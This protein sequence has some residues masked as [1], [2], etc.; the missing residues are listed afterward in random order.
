MNAPPLAELARLDD[1][2][3][4]RALRRQARS[5]A[6]GARAS[7]ATCS[8]AIGNSGDAALAAV[9][10]ERLDDEEPLVRGAAVWA[11]AQLLASEEFAALAKRGPE[12]SATLASPRNGASPSASVPL[13]APF[14]RVPPSGGERAL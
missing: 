11:L 5:S 4:P 7:C 9:A 14:A 1:A 13:I 3:V 12:A 2:G 10:P 6:S 8:I